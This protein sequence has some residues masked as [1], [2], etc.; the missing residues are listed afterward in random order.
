MN[1]WKKYVKDVQKKVFVPV[2]L[3]HVIS[4]KVLRLIVSSLW[5]VLSFFGLFSGKQLNAHCGVFS[6]L[7]T[8]YLNFRTLLFLVYLLLFR[9]FTIL[10]SKTI[11]SVKVKCFT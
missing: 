9:N 11:V 4:S 7:G 2:K 10:F 3:P 8:V 1:K 5:S 6:E